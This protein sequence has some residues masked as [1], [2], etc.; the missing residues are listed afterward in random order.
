[1]KVLYLLR[2]AKSSWAD[3]GRGDFDRPL[4]RRGQEASRRLAQRLAALGVRPTLILCSSARRA[5]ETLAG[6]RGGLDA[7]ATIRMRKDLYEASAA[8]ILAM[9]RGL[10]DAADRAMVIGHNPGLEDVARALAERGEVDARRRIFTKYPTSALAILAAAVDRWRDF[11]PDKARLVAFVRPR[12]L[13][14]C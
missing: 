11:G 4:S 12:D 9:V 7:G 8:T 2:H 3:A 10:D 13:A 6:I 14:G 1:M 5:E